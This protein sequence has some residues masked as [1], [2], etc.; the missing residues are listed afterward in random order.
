[1]RLIPWDGGSISVLLSSNRQD[2]GFSIR[3]K[4]HPIVKGFYFV[5]SEKREKKSVDKFGELL[6]LFIS[7]MRVLSIGFCLTSYMT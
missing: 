3:G 1:M 5:S 4:E 6:S 7:S 2:H